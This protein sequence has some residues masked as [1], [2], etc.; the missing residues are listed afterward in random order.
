MYISIEHIANTIWGKGKLSQK[1]LP[2]ISQFES[3]NI[4]KKI[5][6]CPAND[7]NVTAFP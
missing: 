4:A 7:K 2:V 3:M 6:F 1:N 5:L